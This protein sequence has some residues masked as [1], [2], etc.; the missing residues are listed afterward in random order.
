MNNSI[1]K[2]VKF[3]DFMLLKNKKRIPLLMGLELTARCNNNCRHC[4]INFSQGDKNAKKK[5]LSFEQIKRIID[6]ASDSGVLWC[7]VSGGEPLLR[8]DFVD[9]YTYLI[10]KGFLVSVLTNATLLNQKHM[11]LFKKHPP[12][13]LEVSVYGISEMTYEQ[14]SGRSGSF[15]AFMQGIRLLERAGLNIIFKVTAMQSN[16][17]EINEIVKFCKA[18]DSGAETCFKIN[19]LLKSRIDFNLKR[20]K[21]IRYERLGSREFKK[22]ESIYSSAYSDNESSC[23]IE[24]HENTYGGNL[25]LCNAGKNSFWVGYDGQAYLCPTMRHHKL[26]YNLNKGEF[27]EFWNKRVPDWLKMTS[28]NIDYINKCGQ[29]SIR[30]ECAWCPAWSYLET[31]NLDTPLEYLC[32]L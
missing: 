15:R 22:L 8:E 24:A 12:K 7:T 32:N 17:N 2:K 31:G 26:S 23:R 6:D 19:G 1:V 5:E 14:V 10:N 4:Y 29:C 16:K 30:K 18:F 11:A 27:K 20:N 21:L 13:Q 3:A 25:F 9:I 28:H